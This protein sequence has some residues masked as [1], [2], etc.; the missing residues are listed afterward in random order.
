MGEHC[1]ERSEALSDPF[2]HPMTDSKFSLTESEFD[3]PYQ[4]KDRRGA[5]N[6]PKFS[7]LSIEKSL[8]KCDMALTTETDLKVQTYESA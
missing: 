4:S 2:K 3:D 1:R 5:T 7:D 8:E 6:Q